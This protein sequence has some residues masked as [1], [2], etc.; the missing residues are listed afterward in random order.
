MVLV[1]FVYL[2]NLVQISAKTMVNKQT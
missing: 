1:D 2:S